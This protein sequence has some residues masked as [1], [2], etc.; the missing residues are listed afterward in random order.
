MS[1][2][3]NAATRERLALILSSMIRIREN[4]WVRDT[5]ETVF[6]EALGELQDIMGNAADPVTAAPVQVI[7]AMPVGQVE[8]FVDA[9][10]ARIEAGRTETQAAVVEAVRAELDGADLGVL[11]AIAQT[12]ADLLAAMF[13]PVDPADQAGE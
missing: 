9:A 3:I 1:T 8:A 2:I 12:R 13:P 6:R 10:V 4:G 11:D 5:G 7:H